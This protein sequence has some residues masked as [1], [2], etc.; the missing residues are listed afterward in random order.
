MYRSK[1]DK[2]YDPDWLWYIFVVY[3][4]FLKSI[5]PPTHDLIQCTMKQ[6][7]G[8]EIAIK[9][10]ESLHHQSRR[11]GKTL[12]LSVVMV[13]FAEL[14]F[15][16]CKGKVIYRCPHVN[17]LKGLKQWLKQNPF[18][19]KTR[20]AEYEVDLFECPFPLDVACISESTNVGLECSVLIEDEYSTIDKESEIYIWMLDTKAF[21]AKG[22][23]HEK[24]HISASSGRKNTPFEDEYLYLYEHDPDAYFRMPWTECPWINQAFIDKEK[25]KM[26]DAAYWIEEQYE[27]LW[28]AAHGNF[29]DQSKLHIVDQAFL[30]RFAPNVGGLDWNGE[31]VGHV[32]GV[33]F[34]DEENLYLLDEII[35]KTVPDVNRFI[36]DHPEIEFEVEG[37]PKT[38]GFN[39]GFSDHLQSLDTRCSYQNWGDKDDNVKDRRL[40][41]MQKC[42][43]YCSAKNRWFIKNHKEAT[44]DKKVT[45]MPKLLK[46]A[47]QHG[48][49]YAL[50]MLHGGGSLDMVA[51]IPY[52]SAQNLD[53]MSDMIRMRSRV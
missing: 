26:F 23:I 45:M 27:C 37:R 19:V 8:Y 52:Q 16:P 10:P 49:D 35:F 44:Y 36:N 9:K 43:V 34:W 11:S 21:L 46:T 42:N 39:A 4:R 6:W 47:D 2:E 30:S 3:W 25:K 41:L 15:G 40:A 13:F 22:A 29:F 48:L 5:L 12:K 32:M 51:Q 18:Y 50:H 38:M 20:K 24:R 1:P 7:K 28:V 53:D 33:G 17:Q 31:S 14:G